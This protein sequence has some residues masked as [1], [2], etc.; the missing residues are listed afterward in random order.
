MCGIL[1]LAQ[2]GDADTPL[3]PYWSSLQSACSQRGPHHL[4]QVCVQTALKSLHLNASV[5]SLR[6]SGLTQQPIG[7]EDRRFVLSWNGQVYAFDRIGPSA[8]AIGLETAQTR[9]DAGDNDG[10]IVF[11]LLQEAVEYHVAAGAPDAV[12]A[13]L[14]DLTSSIE[15]EW[16]MLLLDTQ[17]GMIYYGRDPLGRRSLLQAARRPDGDHAPHLLLCSVASQDTL[18]AGISFTE[19]DCGSMWVWNSQSDEYPRPI[20]SRSPQRML[21]HE[22]DAHATLAATASFP[23]PTPQQRSEALDAVRAQLCESISRR[24]NMIQGETLRCASAVASSQSQARVAILF[25]G[26]LDSTLLAQLAHLTM[27]AD[28]T[29]ELINVAFENPRVLAAAGATKISARTSKEGD[30]SDARFNTPDRLLS[31]QS[32]AQLRKLSPGRIWLP[33]EINVSYN[34]YLTAKDEILATMHPCDSVMDL[35][36]AAVLYFASRGHAGEMASRGASSR[37]YLSGLGADELFG[38]YS[39]HLKAFTLGGGDVSDGWCKAVEELQM[40]LDRLPT[41]NL[42]RDD[43]ILSCHGRE[44]RYPFLALPFI[45]LVAALPI[46]VKADFTRDGQDGSRGDKLLL[47]ELARQ[48]GLVEVSSEK[49]RAMQFGARSAKM[50]HG[51]GRIKGHESLSIRPDTDSQATTAP[52]QESAMQSTQPAGDTIPSEVFTTML[53]DPCPA[54]PGTALLRLL[55]EPLS[56]RW[57]LGDTNTTD[58]NQF[59]SCDDQLARHIPLLNAHLQRLRTSSR[60]LAELYPA[61]WGSS[62]NRLARRAALA[63]ETGPL[64]ILSSHLERCPAGLRECRRRIRWSLSMDGQWTIVQSGLAQTV[65]PTLNVR[66]DTIASNPEERSETTVKDKGAYGAQLRWPLYTNKTDVRQHYDDARARTGASYTSGSD[67]SDQSKSVFDVL[68]WQTARAQG[69]ANE[70]AM[71]TE[72]SIANI[73]VERK[74]GSFVTPRLRCSPSDFESDGAVCF[75]PGLM[76]GELLKAGHV[77]EDDIVIEDGRVKDVQRIWLCNALRGVFEVNIVQ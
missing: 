30:P 38:G 20:L 9:L 52:A 63:D 4:G 53:Y 55:P 13:A 46:R 19:V 14:H 10:Q 39:R 34:D 23:E 76:R 56:T 12:E 33:I 44:G 58:S 49:K 32:L 28:A 2:R 62:A 35:S 17:T 59:G 27:P 54:S 60:S 68:L 40:D 45:R 11:D 75:L 67:P 42:G 74:D 66:L 8:A 64:R 47:R 70:C 36:L 37:V 3:P 77:R 18:Q 5:L 71:L 22:M 21:L 25:S 43:R 72:S 15:G 65:S 41:R 31:H 57:S 24:A 1:F 6:G 16:A 29:I 73:I 48:L 61:S 26:G 50:E 69:Q 7:S 51:V